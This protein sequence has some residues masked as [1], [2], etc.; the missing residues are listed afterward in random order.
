MDT[1]TII[2]AVVAVIMLTAVVV[3]IVS[4]L[5]DSPT[6][7]SNEG[8]TQERLSEVDSEYTIT[9]GDNV[10]GDRY[11]ATVNENTTFTGNFYADH[12][13]FRIQNGVIYGAYSTVEAIGGAIATTTPTSI[14]I[15]S[16][17]FIV[18]TSS[19]SQ[20]V[21]TDWAYTTDSEG[22]FCLATNGA[23][24]QN[25]EAVHMIRTITPNLLIVNGTTGYW[26]DKTFTTA[27]PFT[28]SGDIDRFNSPWNFGPS[29]TI[30]QIIIPYEFDV[31]NTG[32]VY[33]LTSLIPVLLAVSIV[34][35]IAYTFYSKRE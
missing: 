32:I 12:Y 15:S 29:G 27:D 5:T 30:E 4:G 25:E 19:G 3:P 11:K 10:T 1:K 21:N 13:W 17:Q 35:G 8:Y 7:Y 23:Y 18:T 14:K 22:S 33:T 16:S 31:K 28:K 34:I 9:W 20:T 24:V 26:S 6:H 2:G